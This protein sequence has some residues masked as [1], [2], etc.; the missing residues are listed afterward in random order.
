MSGL[1]PIPAAPERK[2][3]RLLLGRPV[4]NRKSG[5]VRKAPGPARSGWNSRSR[6]RTPI[7]PPP[8]PG[9][10]AP[11]APEC[12]YASYTNP[13][14]RQRVFWAGSSNSSTLP[15]R[16]VRSGPPN[17]TER[18]SLGG[19]P[20]CRRFRPLS[21]QEPWRPFGQRYGRRRHAHPSPSRRTASMLATPTRTPTRTGGR[22]V[23]TPAQGGGNAR[24]ASATGADGGAWDAEGRGCGTR[25][26]AASAAAGRD[27]PHVAHD[28]QSHGPRAPLPPVR[29]PP[30]E[31]A[32]ECRVPACITYRPLLRRRHA[33]VGW[34]EVAGTRK[35]VTAWE[36]TSQ[37]LL[38]KA[39]DFS[40]ASI[41]S[42]RRKT[43]LSSDWQTA[44]KRLCRPKYG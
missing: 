17:P 5:G 4:A 22:A 26:E 36:T 16:S 29:A 13:Q 34:D 10:S 37:T 1:P 28:A 2:Q 41:T 20:H 21:R 43:A 33:T 7:Q 19:V 14:H 27:R 42:E 35:G 40:C 23:L 15:T 31:R 18:E 8:G 12:T 3:P 44:R 24:A 6:P 9:S 39:L 38:D 11:P 32:P 25:E 30:S